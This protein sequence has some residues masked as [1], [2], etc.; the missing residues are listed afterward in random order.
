VQHGEVDTESVRDR[1][2]WLSAEIREHDRRYYQEAR[3][4]VSDWE[5]DALVRELRELE[6]AHPEWVLTDS[7]LR[8]V[9]GEVI[10]RFQ[11][12]RHGVPML[13]LDNL[14]ADEGGEAAVREW[15]AGVERLAGRVGLEWH[16]EQKIDGVAV[17]LRY[18]GG[19][20]VAGATRGDGEV[21]D[22]ITHNLRTIRSIPLRLEN[23]PDVLEVRGEVYMAD[24]AFAALCERM[25]RAGEDAFA[26]SR[27][28]TAGALKLLDSGEAA[29]RPMDVFLYGLG[30]VSES[31]GT[32]AEVIRWLGELGFRTPPFS[33]VARDADGVIA[34]IAELDVMRRAF[35]FET[36]GAVIK[37]NDL[38][39]REGLGSTARAPR[40]ARAYKFVPDRAQTV[41][42]DIVFQ[43]GRSGALTPVAVLRPVLLR[44]STIARATL[45]NED[46]IR[47]KDLRCGDTVVIQKAGEVIPEVLEV[48]VGLRKEGAEAFDFRGRL[49]GG[50]PVC[51]GVVSRDADL[52]AWFCRNVDCGAQRMR[53]LQYFASKAALDLEGLGGIVA[54]RLVESG[55]VEDPLVL[56]R[57]EQE[58]V[59][60][61]RLAGLN[62]GTEAEPRVFGAKNAAKLSEAVRRA[63]EAGLERWLVALGIPDLGAT[64]AARVAES[65]SD[66]DAVAASALLRAVVRRDVALGEAER[67]NPRARGNRGLS[68]AERTALEARHAALLAEVAELEA[69]L[70]RGDFAERSKASGGG[71]LPRV[72]PVVAGSVIAYFEGERGREVLRVLG[73]LGIRPVGSSGG[74]MR[75]ASRFSGKTVVVTG[76]F[77]GMTRGEV[78]AALRGV[79]AKVVAAVSGTTDFLI[80]G[81][82]GG[83]K[84]DDAERLGVT[85]LGETDL[86]AALT[87]EGV[88]TESLGGERGDGSRAEAAV[89]KLQQGELF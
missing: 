50:C 39:L 84:R 32:Q 71:V 62:L 83:S 41:L 27:N 61:E 43:V 52:S 63:R 2:S 19:V 5:Y 13:S 4:T 67:A 69:E 22:D 77:T 45:H 30:E 3:P 33:R 60:A 80:A 24:A 86:R 70:V 9:G 64:L 23:A 8:R 88:V 66:L 54:D 49:A 16:V 44:G 78:T 56:F 26:N 37:L 51:G 65:H 68:E 20:L 18:E 59:L 75:V 11:A 21:G 25:E 6:G 14:Y 34:A 79:G 72:G 76:S 58:G 57:W 40:W 35:G 29:T 73:E 74:G 38:S 1:I 10:S 85:V 15:V 82:G 31:P 7:P 46:E 81:E 36:D 87:G 42:E 17:N 28:A 47:R 89:G 12:F 55:L 48:V 53:R